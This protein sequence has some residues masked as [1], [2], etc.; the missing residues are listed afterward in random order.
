MQTSTER[1]LTTHVGS[2]PRSQAV[3]D[4]LFGREHGTIE[5][6]AA[7]A[8]VIADATV[9]VV[10]K[11]VAAGI[12]VVSD[13]EMS[14]IS[15]ATYVADRF[16]GFEGDTPRDPGQDLVEFPRLLEK[17]AKLGSTAK[18][19]RP[20]CVG[21]IRTKTLEPLQED[22]RN[23]SRAVAAGKP[24]DAFLNAASPGVIALFQPND[25]YRNPDDYLEAVAEALRVEYEAI[26]AAGFLVQI[27][28]PDLGMGRH[29]MYRN[30]SVPEYLARAALHVEVL[31]HALRNI[32]ASRLRMHCCWGNYEGPHHHDIPMRELLP[33]LLEAKPQ[34]LLFEAAN[35]RHA[36]EWTVFRDA[37]LPDDKILIPGVLSST[38]NYVEHPELVAERLLKFADIVGRERVMAGS[39]CGFSTFAGFGAVDPDIVYMKLAAMAEGARLAS[40]R[41]W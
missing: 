12:D 15:Y 31:N 30:A 26:V 23:F 29:T 21:E 4:V 13:G 10:A 7:A 8:R 1:I 3:T 32:P 41:L 27:D 38:T 5:D 16:T 2:L 19:R 35:P 24:A 18:Y 25:F 36:H 11:Q 14:K 9:E 20:R 37:R 6:A 33:V 28:A 17:L 40:D 22:L 39:D 34:A